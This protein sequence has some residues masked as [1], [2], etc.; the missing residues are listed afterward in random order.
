MEIEQ[1]GFY[2]E[3]KS[4]HVI[5]L[6]LLYIGLIAGI[7]YVMLPIYADA[8]THFIFTLLYVHALMLFLSVYRGAL[9]LSAKKKSITLADIL[10]EI[11][12]A[13]SSISKTWKL[14]IQQKNVLHVVA[15][16]VFMWAVSFFIPKV[17]K[18]FGPLYFE[19]GIVYFASN[20]VEMLALGLQGI[21]GLLII[22]LLLW[23]FHSVLKKNTV[24]LYNIMMVDELMERIK[25]RDIPIS[26][27]HENGK[28]IMDSNQ[29]LDTLA[30]I[31][32]EEAA[33]LYWQVKESYVYLQQIEF[34][35]FGRRMTKG[36]RYLLSMKKGREAFTC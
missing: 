2:K 26:Y 13:V 21:A 25:K 12:I 3:L 34:T 20:V 35:P 32:L 17:L 27:K 7:T 15:L 1:S 28:T 31:P 22:C 14:F 4:K 29:L 19:K 9:N 16:F 23:T 18:T 6:V 36:E 5:I 24:H 11:E 33:V 10:L 8:D 30:Q